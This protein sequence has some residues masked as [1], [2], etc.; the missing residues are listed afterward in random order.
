M[1]RSLIILLS[2]FALS[3]QGIGQDLIERSQ[4]QLPSTSSGISLVGQQIYHKK[5]LPILNP[6]VLNA[7]KNKTVDDLYG[8]H[9]DID[10][11]VV[12]AL[13]KKQEYRLDIPVDAQHSVSLL[14]Y[15]FD[16]IAPSYFI[17]DAEE[18]SY[19]PGHLTFYRGVVSDDPSAIATMSV[20]DH[21]IRILISDAYGN[22]NVGPIDDREDYI[23]YND[24]ELGDIPYTCESESISPVETATPDGVTIK[25]EGTEKANECVKV[26]VE[27][28]YESYTNLNNGQGGTQ[29]QKIARVETFILG[30]FAQVATLYDNINIPVQVSGVKVWTTNDP[31]SAESN[32]GTALN[33]LNNNINTFP[34]DLFHLVSAKNSNSFSGIAY[35]SCR[36]SGPCKATTLGSNIP[37]AVSQTSL[38]YNTV[39]NYSWT[40]AVLAHEMG[41]NMGSPHTHECAWGPNNNTTIDECVNQ[42]SCGSHNP[43]IQQGQGTI[44]S[45]CHLTGVGTSFSIGFGD[46]VGPH[47]TSE[48]QYALSTGAVSPCVVETEDPEPTE[49]TCTSV[50]VLSAEWVSGF[51]SDL[52]GWIQ[53]TTD[54]I[55]WTR[56][57]GQTPSNGTGPSTN[58]SIQGS[59]YIYVEA[60]NPNY[61]SKTSSITS[62]CVDI[63]ALTNPTLSF[64]YHMYGGAMGS[65]AVNVI[66][67]NTGAKTQLWSQSGNRGDSWYGVSI[68]ISAYSNIDFS[69][70]FLAETGSD[71]TSDIAIDDIA[72]GGETASCTD[73][74]Q[75]GTETGIDCGGS[76]CIPCFD[77]ERQNLTINSTRNIYGTQ[78][79]IVAN[80]LTVNAPVTVNTNAT[81]LWQAGGGISINS[82]FEIKAGAEVIISSEDCN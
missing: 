55:D 54:D 22:Y 77:C 61:P 69:I 70:E 28:D 48:Y 20:S 38:S 30:A 44:M 29:A 76:S 49:P 25:K 52:D 39:P 24:T 66:N 32:V 45:Y 15:P 72:I 27:M 23:F 36:G 51:E 26:Y 63:S 35:L 42:P 40:V 19:E 2:I 82:Q 14:L 62:P 59:Y 11:S 12:K 68:D 37:F 75:N 71:F 17:E 10:L 81:L 65:L 60:S 79:E 7:D 73:G 74:I 46:E 6:F 8:V 43:T 3:Y 41:H 16:I 56:Q 33:Y 5:N 18:L 64:S 34:G 9:L 53:S 1:I 80:N 47:L 4:L 31:Y 57:S 78:D 21:G 67:G 13:H 50:D 58:G